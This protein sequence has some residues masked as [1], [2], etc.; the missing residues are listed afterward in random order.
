MSSRSA[1]LARIGVQHNAS[2][3]DCVAVPGPVQF[4]T[5]A[6][7]NQFGNDGYKVEQAH[8]TEIVT[9]VVAPDGTLL[10]TFRHRRSAAQRA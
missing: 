6:G 2:R 3:E 7:V 5:F 1:D 4:H 10:S 8:D 9:P